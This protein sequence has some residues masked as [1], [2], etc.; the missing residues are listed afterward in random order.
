MA[1]IDICLERRWNAFE[2]LTRIF[3][4]R[5]KA[6]PPVKAILVIFDR[7]ALIFFV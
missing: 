7:W 4:Q 3:F 2:H 1:S 6:G 5:L